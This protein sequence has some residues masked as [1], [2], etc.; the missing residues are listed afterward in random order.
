MR[1]P[2]P[3]AFAQ[4]ILRAL[5]DARQTDTIAGDLLEEYR[6]RVAHGAGI[7]ELRVWYFKQVLSFV[8][9]LSLRRDLL[10]GCLGWVVAAA[11]LELVLLFLVPLVAGIPPEWA[12]FCF[13]AVILAIAGAR[14]MRTS[15]ERRIVFQTST[16]WMLP[17]VATAYMVLGSPRFSPV[18][19]V[20][21]FFLCSA[22]AALHASVRTHKAGHGVA[23]ATAVGVLIALSTAVATISPHHPHPPLAS[24][25]FLPGIAAIVGVVGASFGARFGRLSPFEQER[26]SIAT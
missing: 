4:S 10:P 17:F 1:Q 18:L 26:L 15:T 19:G 21:A 12:V 23:A 25:L 20:G 24:F 16:L 22:G 14:A 2:N 9:C 13:V 3:P 6:D 7:L 5:L 11:A 8:D